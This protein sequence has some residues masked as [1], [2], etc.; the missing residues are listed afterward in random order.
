MDYSGQILGP[1]NKV[2]AVWKT[3]KKQ[4]GKYRRRGT[5]SKGK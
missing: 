3:V 5:T 1:G 2:K 4:A